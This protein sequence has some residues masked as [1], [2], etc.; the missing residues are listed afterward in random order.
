QR[1]A[2][3]DERPGGSIIDGDRPG[4]RLAESDPQ[5]PGR[6]RSA[7][8]LDPCAYLIARDDRL[9]GTPGLGHDRRD[10]RKGRD[11]SSRHLGSHPTGS[12]GPTTTPQL[13]EDLVSVVDG[14]QE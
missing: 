5:L 11:A 6:K 10:A 12:Q 2:P 4:H 9:E 8:R 7:T 3:A 14:R 1:A 13:I